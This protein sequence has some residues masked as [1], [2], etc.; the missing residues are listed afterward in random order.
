MISDETTK[1]APV[2]TQQRVAS[3][4]NP[5]AIK[6]KT[7]PQLSP[8]VPLYNPRTP[9]PTDYPFQDSP[10]PL[11]NVL[12]ELSS[13][14][15]PPVHAQAYFFGSTYGYSDSY[16]GSIMKVYKNKDGRK[17]QAGLGYDFKN[18]VNDMN[19]KYWAVVG[20]GV[21]LSIIVA[22]VALCPAGGAALTFLDT[23]N[24]F[25]GQFLAQVITGIV[26]L[27]GNFKV[28]LLAFFMGN[29]LSY[30][31]DSHN[32]AELYDKF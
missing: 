2:I 32:V 27:P 17:I 7:L 31:Y 30:L 6:V 10:L 23:L 9:N 21:T 24:S 29:L 11:N 4:S 28:G 22:V 1:T 26:G 8:K 5:E 15:K 12:N 25:A 19:T 13:E 18:A 14:M 3:V 16:D 20:S